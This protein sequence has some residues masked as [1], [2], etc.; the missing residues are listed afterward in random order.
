MRPV[1]MTFGAVLACLCL[2]LVTASP[3]ARAMSRSE[4]WDPKTTWVLVVGVLEWKDPGLTSFSKVDRRD[5]AFYDLLAARGVP[6]SQRTL[7][8]DQQ[9]TAPKIEAA[10]QD[11]ARRAPKNAT[12][13]VYFAGHGMKTDDG[14]VVLASYDLAPA[15]VAKTGWHVANLPNVLAEFRGQHVMLLADCC[16]SGGLA[17]AAKAIAERG[18]QAIALTSAEASNVSTGNWTYTM[19]LIDGFGGRAILDRDQDGLVTLGELGDEVRDEMRAHEEQRAG[20]AVFGFDPG[21]ALAADKPGPEAAGGERIDPGSGPFARGA[22]VN[23]P[24][25][26]RQGDRTKDVGRVLAV[27]GDELLVAFWGYTSETRVWVPRA[28]V[29]PFVLK[30]FPVG[31]KLQV[32]WNGVVY[33]ARVTAVNDGFM[34]ITYPGWGAEWDEWIG[35]SRVVGEGASADDPSNAGRKPIKVE[36][37]GKWYDA[38]VTERKGDTTCIHYLGYA[39][40]WDECV[41]KSRIRP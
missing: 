25:S 28:A 35:P 38:V 2:A 23:A 33:D 13:I 24:P 7:L 37:N 5:Q 4:S 12:L 31:S 9:A 14:E 32:T 40:S 6:E 34:R 18:I 19:T 11:L 29:L 3:R 22:F 16:F 1:R 27:R 30:A 41:P 17:A 10:L 39:A 15:K 21:F 36:W 8:L 26:G 20:V